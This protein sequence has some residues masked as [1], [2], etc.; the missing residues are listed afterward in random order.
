MSRSLQ[1]SVDAGVVR[2]IDVDKVTE[3]RNTLLTS[4]PR[5]GQIHTALIP[6]PM[7]QT[8][9]WRHFGDIRGLTLL[10]SSCKKVIENLNAP[11][12]QVDRAQDS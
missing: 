10:A 4:I 1:T 3:D 8:P 7:H 12:A 2:K 6:F 5:A 9:A 11:V